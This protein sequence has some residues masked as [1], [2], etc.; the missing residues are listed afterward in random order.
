MCIESFFV[1]LFYLLMRIFVVIFRI[2]ISFFLLLFCYSS[3]VLL[4]LWGE[5]SLTFRFDCCFEDNM[6]YKQVDNTITSTFKSEKIWF[7]GSYKYNMVYN[8]LVTL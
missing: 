7:D 2:F 6:I 4:C 5:G 1:V 3:N 8:M